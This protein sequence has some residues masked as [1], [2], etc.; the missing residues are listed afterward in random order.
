LNKAAQ[1]GS[2]CVYLDFYIKLSRHK[3]SPP[4]TNAAVEWIVVKGGS[5]L[6]GDVRRLMDGV[7]KT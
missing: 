6:L 1:T 7:K 3:I 5:S 2:P 4:L